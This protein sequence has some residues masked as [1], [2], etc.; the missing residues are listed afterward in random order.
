MEALLLLIKLGDFPEL[1]TLDDL[2]EA[3]EFC[4]L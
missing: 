3:I 1:F 4:L 2:E